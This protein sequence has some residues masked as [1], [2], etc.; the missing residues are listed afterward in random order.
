MYNGTVLSASDLHLDLD[1]PS[2]VTIAQVG[3]DMY[4]VR[5]LE[6]STA[7]VNVSLQLPWSADGLTR[8]VSVWEGR[9]KYRSLDSVPTTGPVV[10]ELQPGQLYTV[11]RYRCRTWAT[12]GL[13]CPQSEQKAVLE[14]AVVAE[15]VSRPR[16]LFN[17]TDLPRLR[18][19]VHSQ[20]WVRP[21]LSQYM[22]TFHA[23][24][25]TGKQACDDEMRSTTLAQMSAILFL[26]SHSSADAISY[27]VVGAEEEI[28]SCRAL[29]ATVPFTNANSTNA[30]GFSLQTYRQLQG[31]IQVFDAVASA[32]V[33]N[34]SETTHIEDVL[35]MTTSR[36]MERCPPPILPHCGT[37]FNEW[38]MMDD[39]PF[40]LGNIN[41]DRLVSVGTFALAFP[42]HPKSP[43]Y[44]DHAVHELRYQLNYSVFSDGAWQGGIRY[45]GAVLRCVVP[46]AYALRMANRFDAFQDDNF[47][48]LL[49][50]FFEV[51]T[52]RDK[53]ANNCA[54]TPA[55]SDSL[56]EPSW[57][58]VLGWAAAGA[59]ESDP[60]FAA[61]LS[62]YW[63]RA[64]SP[65]SV[66]NSPGNWLVPFLFVDTQLAPSRAQGTRPSVHLSSGITVLRSI[67]GDDTTVLEGDDDLSY[68]LLSA[69]TQR[70]CWHQ[71]PD[72]GAIS[73]L[74]YDGVP[75][76]LDAGV[77]TSYSDASFSDWYK[78]SKAHSMMTFGEADVDGPASVETLLLLPSLIDVVAV[79]ISSALPPDG[80]RYVRTIYHHK[81][82]DVYLVHDAFTVLGDTAASTSM[83]RNATNNLHVLTREPNSTGCALRP[84]AG[85]GV[86]L[87]SC[88]GFLGVSL[89]VAIL[90]P[91]ADI[92]PAVRGLNKQEHSLSVSVDH[93][94]T[95]LVVATRNGT[96]MKT[97]PPTR[98]QTWLRIRQPAAA[99]APPQDFITIL[100]P[101]KSSSSNQRRVD[102]GI[103]QQGTH[104]TVTIRT[105]EN[106]TVVYLLRPRTTRTS[107]L[108]GTPS[109]S[110]VVS[111]QEHRSSSAE[112]ASALLVN[113]TQL[114]FANLSVRCARPASVIVE[115]RAND[116]Y[117]VATLEGDCRSLS[118]AL[119]WTSAV[120]PSAVRVYS[121]GHAVAIDGHVSE[122]GECSFAVERRGDYTVEVY[123]GL[124]GP[125]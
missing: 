94:P 81:G 71:H 30:S 118:L 63:E 40:R 73:G 11:E 90:S 86:T 39:E 124:V 20:D 47:K 37:N 69:D 120:D 6:D 59:A 53:T 9:H 78:T 27:A 105:D 100:R 82:L 56:W 111:L 91:S 80:S 113:G 89:D 84:P 15:A 28:I 70:S 31:V 66:E 32:G 83:L 116:Q 101:Y 87:L 12:A 43:A 1:A 18:A 88:E 96:S 48:A 26:T 44:L 24:N 122:S 4:Q 95:T 75:L 110:A 115:R 72:R 108:L 79:D 19:K 77:P 104:S 29:E 121:Q 14:M 85:D 50:Y 55:V 92:A 13:D 23:C 62:F 65:L 42:N 74:Y 106:L 21:M 25:G 76:M 114:Q 103:E 60:A 54:L 64:C 61:E 93:F 107:V 68:F 3:V 36:L 119:P 41:T 10:F 117:R 49:R 35:A 22:A 123:H 45:H 16:L 67:R 58:A 5:T 52:P 38:D 109:T 51:Q 33:F 125:T 8:V 46:L 102:Y 97:L 99:A 17:T 7:A 2:T 98:F 57:E 112:I 34:E